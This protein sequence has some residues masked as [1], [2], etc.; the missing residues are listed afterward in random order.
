MLEQE[1]RDDAESFHRVMTLLRNMTLE[2]GKCHPREAKACT[3]CNAEE[4]LQV[5]LE[6]YKGPRIVASLSNFS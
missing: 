1:I 4:E 3:N 2:H 6:N 5:M